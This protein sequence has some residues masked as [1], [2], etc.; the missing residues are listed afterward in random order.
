MNVLYDNLKT[1]TDIYSNIKKVEENLAVLEKYKDSPVS[2][3]GKVTG[4]GNST[5]DLNIPGLPGLKVVPALMQALQE[6]KKTLRQ[7]LRGL[8]I[9]D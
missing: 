5:E 3:S 2:L 6:Y 4:K 1:I 9:V 7:E 8:G